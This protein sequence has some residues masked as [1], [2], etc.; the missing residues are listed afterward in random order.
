MGCLEAPGGPAASDRARGDGRG[1]RARPRLC[2]RRRARGVLRLCVTLAGVRAGAGGGRGGAEGGA[3]PPQPAPPSGPLAERCRPL[4]AT[5]GS[6]GPRAPQREGLARG[7]RTRYFPPPQP[8]PAT[9]LPSGGP[10]AAPGQGPALPLPMGTS[11]PSG[12]R[13]RLTC[14][15]R[16]G[17]VPRWPQSAEASSCPASWLQRFLPLSP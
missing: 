2:L 3:P 5:E 11:S 10:P 13:G 6:V 17:W 9:A 15:K 12:G 7:P 16:R 14:G 8:P 4:A 1:Q